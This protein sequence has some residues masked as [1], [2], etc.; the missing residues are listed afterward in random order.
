MEN[1][2][3]WACL[4]CE[5]ENTEGDRCAK[6]GW[7]WTDAKKRANVRPGAVDKPERGRADICITLGLIGLAL[8]FYFL[9]VE[10]TSST[11]TTTVNLH[12]LTLGQTATIVGAIFLAAGIRPR[13]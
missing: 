8:G 10:P 7:S 11:S 3:A 6:C 5:A 1:E 4:N 9:Y 12:R 13:R 2:A